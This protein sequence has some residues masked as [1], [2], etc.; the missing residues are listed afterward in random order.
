MPFGRVLAVLFVLGLSFAA[1]TSLVSMIELS[2]RALVDW[3]MKR[4]QAAWAV[5]G[6]GALIGLPSALN[7][8]FLGNQDFVWGVALM[9]SGAFI[10]FLVSRYGAARLRGE[11]ATPSDWRLPGAWDFVMRW[12]IPLQAVVLLVWWMA[13]ATT[14]GFVGADGHWWDP[15]NPYSLMTVLVQWA[16]VLVAFFLLNRWMTR[17]LREDRR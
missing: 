3:G 2:A 4:T 13:Q 5:A 8:T 14:S 12:L 15:L 9:I 7:L 10:A 17:R 6:V 1:F 16:V 11:I